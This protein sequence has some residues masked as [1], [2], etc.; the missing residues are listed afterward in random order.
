M[1]DLVAFLK[2]RLDEDEQLARAAGNRQWL[3]QDNTI[4]LYPEH[5][6]DGYMRWPT[7]ADA[8]HAANWE[9]ARVL[10]EIEAKRLILSWHGAVKNDKTPWG[11]PVQICRCG[12]DLPCGTL[13]FL[14]LPY[15]D[16]EDYQEAWKP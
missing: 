13:R 16:H 8:R 10:R 4:E 2:A 12:Y 5:E 11:Q 3:V 9:P 1:N 6:D 15:A 14:A 7:R